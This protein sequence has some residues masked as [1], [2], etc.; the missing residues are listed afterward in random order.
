MSGGLLAAG[1]VLGLTVSPAEARTV[2]L[3][4]PGTAENPCTSSLTATVTQA[5][6]ASRTERTRIARRPAIDCFYV[7]PTVSGQPTT[8][9]NRRIDPEQRAIAEQQA[10]R[11]SRVC[12]VW[13]PVYRQLTL[14]AIQNP[15]AVTEAAQRRAYGDVRAAWRDYMANHNR[16]RGVVL[17]GHSQGSFMLLQLIRDEI[18]RHRAMRRQLVSAMLLGGSVAVPKGRSVGGDFRHV[19]TCRTPRQ[20]GCVVAY[21]AFDQPPPPDALFGRLRGRPGDPSRLEILCTNPAALGGGSGPLR[22]YFMTKRFPGV[23]GMVADPPPAAPT[24]WVAF[25]GLYTAHCQR[26]GGATWLQVDDLRPPGD[27]RPRVHQT[28]GPAWGL[29]LVDVNIALGNL[30]DLAGAQAKT[31]ERRRG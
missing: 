23:L 21:S 17:L 14:A 1:V 4:K 8:N 7:Y 29:H 9:A 13:A 11:F 26:E 3:C 5:D 20:I 2:W 28:L 6:G 25:P 19:P 12:R 30:V 27:Q 18:D 31:Y 22:P 16:G 15:A 10:S 24:P